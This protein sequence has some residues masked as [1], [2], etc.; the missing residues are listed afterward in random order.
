MLHQCQ[1]YNYLLCPLVI[2]GACP[3]PMDLGSDW[4]VDSEEEARQMR[5]AAQEE[6][7]LEAEYKDVVKMKSEEINRQQ[8]QGTV[9]KGKGSKRSE[10]GQL[11]ERMDNYFYFKSLLFLVTLR[12]FYTM[13]D[14]SLIIMLLLQYVY[15]K[16][17]SLEYLQKLPNPSLFKNPANLLL[18]NGHSAEPIQGLCL[19]IYLP[20]KI[21]DPQFFHL[22]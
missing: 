21:G 5:K 8:G 7:R 22:S 19:L 3:T 4:E 16:E 2:A 18:K 1:H 12:R 14:Q 9:M 17:C 11:L 15:I 10:F 20:K 13:L 6:N